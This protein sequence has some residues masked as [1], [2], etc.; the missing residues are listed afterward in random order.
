[1]SA[2]GED[3]QDPGDGPWPRLDV[4]RGTETRQTLLLWGQIVGKTRL[5]LC[6]MVNQ[7]WQA[8]LTLTAR[9]LAGLA[10]PIGDRLLDVELDFID[11]RLVARTSDGAVES[12]SLCEQPL[13]GFYAGY[14][15]CLQNLGVEVKISP[16]AV[17]MPDLVR[18]DRD[19]RTCRYDADWARRYFRALIQADRLLKQFR[20]RF[21]GKASPVHLFWG[22][23]DLAATRFSG[24]PAPRHPGGVPHVKDVVMY[25]AYAEEVSSAGFWAGDARF[26]EAAFYGYAYPEPAGFS[27]ARVRPAAAHYHPTLGEFLLPYAA[28]RDA[29]DP[30]GEVLAFLDSTYA[31][32]A[33]L[34]H[35]DRAH[36]ERHDGAPA[37]TSPALT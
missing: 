14:R 35:W 12:M 28:V 15:R 10:M 13:S 26:P 22:A 1:M 23:F 37:S 32:A 21:V 9:G 7:W 33:D 31:A 19:P 30:A 8:A 2:R 34:A 6:P 17:E 11:H 5:A 16:V 3:L 4:G 29:S 27:S 18:L 20:G 25:E 36:L 24:R